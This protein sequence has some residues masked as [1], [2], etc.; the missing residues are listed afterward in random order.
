M[1]DD[2][3]GTYAGYQRHGKAGE[4]PCAACRRAATEYARER[5]K[6]AGVRAE[7]QR[8]EYA[9]ER[10]WSRLAAMHPVQYRALYEEELG[11]G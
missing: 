6:R 1:N 10:A 9:R 2:K 7:E 5:R 11:R 3:C 8:R 4:K